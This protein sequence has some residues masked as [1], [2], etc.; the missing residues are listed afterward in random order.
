MSE[1]LLQLSLREVGFVEE[2]MP[3]TMASRYRLRR[4][5]KA[6]SSIHSRTQLER[7]RGEFGYGGSGCCV[8]VERGRNF[9][10]IMPAI[11]LSSK[12]S[13]GKICRSQQRV[14]IAERIRFLV[15][16]SDLSKVI[17]VSIFLF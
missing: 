17:S 5:S 11:S 8:G 16:I 4:A 13:S 3:N 7:C 10:T 9:L 6:P 14:A 1:L 12:H 2:A 15:K